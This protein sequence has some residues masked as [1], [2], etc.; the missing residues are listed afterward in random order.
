M[1]VHLH[2]AQTEARAPTMS[3]H[4]PV[5]VSLPFMAQRALKVHACPLPVKME[6]PVSQR[7][8]NPFL[9]HVFKDTADCS[10]KPISMNVCRHLVSTVV[11]V[12]I[13]SIPLPVHVHPRFMD[14]RVH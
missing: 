13:V 4:L 8:A 5:P 11:P 3:I 12:R 6:E 14:R 7:L 2:L 9:V 1:N 10:V